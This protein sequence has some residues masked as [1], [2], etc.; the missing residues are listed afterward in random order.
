MAGCANP[1]EGLIRKVDDK[2]YCIHRMDW[3]GMEEDWAVVCKGN[4]ATCGILA[5]IAKNHA[6]S[7]KNVHFKGHLA[8]DT[9]QASADDPGSAFTTRAIRKKR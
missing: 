3:V 9:A 4:A 2:W 8:S 6:I 7:N 1:A 5:A